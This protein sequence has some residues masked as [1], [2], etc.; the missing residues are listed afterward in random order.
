METTL[1]D[2][3]TDA[4]RASWLL[5]MGDTA[6]DVALRVRPKPPPPPA[7]NAHVV[8][9]NSTHLQRMMATKPGY[10]NVHLLV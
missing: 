2:Q 3:L 8:G 5:A 1:S 4:L 6:E 7:N 10:T 9:H